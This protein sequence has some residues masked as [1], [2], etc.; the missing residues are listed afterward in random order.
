MRSAPAAGVASDVMGDYD[1]PVTGADVMGAVRAF[2]ASGIDSERVAKL[3]DPECAV[4]D[5]AALRLLM[6][7]AALGVSAGTWHAVFAP[8]F[9]E[10][11]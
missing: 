10:F 8:L 1:R 9:G 3:L 2:P 11:E 4:P 7:P 5:L 6:P